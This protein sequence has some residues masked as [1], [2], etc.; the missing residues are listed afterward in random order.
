MRPPREADAGRLGEYAR[1]LPE[2]PDPRLSVLPSP[3]PGTALLACVLGQDLT[4]A[5]LRRLLVDLSSRLGP[6]LLRA[7]EVPWDELS[8]RCDLPWLAH[9]PHRDPLPG[10]VTAT[11]D[12]L[13]VHGDPAGWEHRFVRPSELVRALAREI[14]WMGRR[15]PTRVKAWRFARWLAR[16]ELGLPGWS[17]ASREALPPPWPV[18]ER[19]ARSL[20]LLPAG[21]EASSPAER[22][23]WS[24]AF[25][26]MAAPED[27]S[28]LWLPLETLLARGR[29]APACEER[30]PGGCRTC[31]WRSDCPAAAR[32]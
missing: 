15:S 13:R 6:S 16:G 18:L 27:P 5:A 31:P 14:P 26:R 19:P 4:I 3:D 12:F 1:L 2:A 10:W 9:W 23:A 17:A 28:R 29:Q 11:G 21:W 7:W 32:S 30:L 8:R 22:Q 20:S 25:C 24:A